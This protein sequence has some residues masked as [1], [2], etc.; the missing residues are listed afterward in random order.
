ML[1]GIFDG[2]GVRKQ[3]GHWQSSN[4]I[5]PTKTGNIVLVGY[6]VSDWWSWYNFVLAGDGIVT[7]LQPGHKYHVE[8]KVRI[9]TFPF[10]AANSLDLRIHDTLLPSY[11]GYDYDFI[12]SDGNTL[13][14][15]TTMHTPNLLSTADVNIYSTY[16]SSSPVLIAKMTNIHLDSRWNFIPQDYSDDLAV[17]T[18]KDTNAGA[19]EYIV[20]SYDFEYITENHSG[21][22]IGGSYRPI[23]YRVDFEEEVQAD[24]TFIGQFDRTITEIV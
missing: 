6:F 23:Q 18:N 10:N 19:G 22:E 8:Y 4:L 11:I 24:L 15:N 16:V 9:D 21:F 5:K 20:L 14:K 1:R 12:D 13:T 7:R 3:N 2:G 17:V